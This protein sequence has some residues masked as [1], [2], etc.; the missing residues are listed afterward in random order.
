M[1]EVTPDSRCTAAS[2]KAAGSSRMGASG[3]EL[4]GDGAQC[5]DGIFGHGRDPGGQQVTQGAEAGERGAEV[6]KLGELVGHRAEPGDQV[7]RARCAVAAG[8]RRRAPRWAAATAESTCSGSVESAATGLRRRCAG[9]GWACGQLP[10]GPADGGY[11]E[12]DRGEPDVERGAAWSTCSV[13]SAGRIAGGAPGEVGERGGH[14]AGGRTN[15]SGVRPAGERQ[16]ADVVARATAAPV[17]GRIGR[18]DAVEQPGARHG[19]R[20]RAIASSGNHVAPPSVLR[21]TA[22]RSPAPA[23]RAGVGGVVVPAHDAGRRPRA[24]PTPPRRR[25]RSGGRDEQHLDAP[26]RGP[27]SRRATALTPAPGR[28]GRGRRP[29]RR[30][31]ARRGSRRRRRR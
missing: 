28:A 27:G 9:R 15:S 19:R 17:R 11:V 24:S 13:R 20:R 6:G 22:R 16:R 10:V 26:A 29:A 14:R 2:M 30:S 25:R 23:R 12:L 4:I 3:A 31:P 21:R 5:R 1:V 7:G 18:V 8:R